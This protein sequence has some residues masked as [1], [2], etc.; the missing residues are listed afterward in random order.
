MSPRKAPFNFIQSD[1][2]AAVRTALSCS[3]RSSEIDRSCFHEFAFVLN[4][5]VQAILL[6]DR[7]SR[8]RSITKGRERKGRMDVIF[9]R[10][11]LALMTGDRAGYS[12]SLSFHHAPCISSSCSV[13]LF[14][15][16]HVSETRSVSR[17]VTSFVSRF[18]TSSFNSASFS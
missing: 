11:V 10:F 13:P 4:M 18:L 6:L 1:A 15:P 8:R 12:L 7:K 2:G 14:I 17:R 5:R 3:C 9:S 16:L